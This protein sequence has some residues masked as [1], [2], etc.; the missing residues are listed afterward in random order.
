MA[1]SEVA[2][3]AEVASAA[4]DL[5]ARAPDSAEQGQRDLEEASAAKH[6]AKLE[7]LVSTRQTPDVFLLKVL[8]DWTPPPANAAD[9]TPKASA[10]RGSAA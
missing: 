6:P 5:A 4:E 8:V 2:V 7:T 9:S 1:V 3:S 10:E